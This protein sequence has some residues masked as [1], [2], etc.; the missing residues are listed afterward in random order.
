MHHKTYQR[1]RAK[2]RIA[3]METKAERGI[4]LRRVFQRELQ[5]EENRM[6]RARSA[7]WNAVG[8]ELDRT[9]N[10]KNRRRPIAMTDAQVA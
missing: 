2:M 7:G 4:M 9:L 3:E 5:R 1:L 8:D 6:E 10:T